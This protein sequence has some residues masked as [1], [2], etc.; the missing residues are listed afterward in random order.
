[1]A[2]NV[3]KTLCSFKGLGTTQTAT[4]RH[5]PED[6]NQK[7]HQCEKF[8][9]CRTY[10]SYKYAL[11]QLI[12]TMLHIYTGSANQNIISPPRHSLANLFM[13]NLLTPNS[14]A[15]KITTVMFTETWENLHSSIWPHA[16][17]LSSGLNTSH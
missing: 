8:K 16:I 9:S 5:I 14:F 15:L 7:H 3:Q 12:K 13:G 2:P 1:M 17:S 11:D 10:V 4:Q 6:V